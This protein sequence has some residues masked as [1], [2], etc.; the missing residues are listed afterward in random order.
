MLVASTWAVLVVSPVSVIS[1]KVVVIAASRAATVVVGSRM[2]VVIEAM[3]FVTSSSWLGAIVAV[4]EDV[5]VVSAA[6]A[7]SPAASSF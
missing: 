7:P 4:A 2:V 5:E 3:P 1:L 6:G